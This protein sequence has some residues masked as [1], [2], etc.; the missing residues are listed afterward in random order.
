MWHETLCLTCGNRFP[1]QEGRSE[2]C[3]YCGA[4]A[5]IPNFAAGSEGSDRP[6]PAL[7]PNYAGL[8]RAA[9]VLRILAVLYYI[10]GGLLALWALYLVGTLGTSC[11][12]HA[13]AL[14]IWT[15][16]LITSGAMMDGLGEAGS[17][18]RDLA[19]NSWT[20]RGA[21]RG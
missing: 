18:L 11:F 4:L 14:L 15:G 20:A 16:G 2:T 8:V 5:R 6:A 12:P 7:L 1:V 10:G 17:A 3:P 21:I 13:G 19:R 9:L